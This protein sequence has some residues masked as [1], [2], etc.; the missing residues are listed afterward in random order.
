MKAA[1]W[2]QAGEIV[3]EDIP[4]PVP[5]SNEALVAVE[6]VGLCGSDAEEYTEGP[7]VARPPVTLGHEIVGVVAA[8]AAD[9]SG[10][11]AGTRVVVD[12]VTGCGSCYWCQRHDEG[13]CP[14]LL[15][16]GLHIDGGLAEFVVGRADRL[17]P[18]P[19]GLL[20]QHAALAEPLAV[21]VRALRKAEPV[22]GAG[23]LVVG[24]GTIG[25]LTAQLAASM[26]A[27][28]VVVVEP[29][30]QR[31]QL[32]STWNITAVWEPDEPGR[33]LALRQMFPER[34][35]DVVFEC[36]GRSGM[37]GEAARR[38]RPGGTVV[39]LGVT[40]GPE[41]MD[42]L[43][44]VLHEKDLRGSAA[45]MWDD[46]VAVAVS[47]LAAGRVDVARLISHVIPLDDVE[48]AFRKL[49]DPAEKTLKVLV[50]VA[51]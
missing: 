47:V 25:M 31:R 22:Q 34:G 15:V 28:P 46:D 1:R 40:A 44:L 43:D 12:V 10:P 20:P 5:R 41:P 27:H 4:T 2:H 36:A 35:I 8:P 32:L 19:A 45:H 26:G 6:W 16:T 23:V 39:L 48:T 13:L 29:D 33:A 51:S 9:G 37:V 11:V 24:G 50:R 7:V 18:V 21:A 17:I 3:L 30:E 42:V 14:S 38:A 49:I